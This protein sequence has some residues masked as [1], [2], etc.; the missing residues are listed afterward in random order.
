VVLGF[1]HEDECRR[2]HDQG[3]SARPRLSGRRG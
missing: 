3:G 1:Q 2:Q